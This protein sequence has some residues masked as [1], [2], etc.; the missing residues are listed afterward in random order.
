MQIYSSST[1]YS[2]D[3]AAK[4]EE[5]VNGEISLNGSISFAKGSILLIGKDY[6]S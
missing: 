5:K 1:Y 2:E 6:L 3:S 4:I